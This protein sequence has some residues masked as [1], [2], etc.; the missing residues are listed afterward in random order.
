MREIKFRAWNS[1]MNKFTDPYLTSIDGL[2]NADIGG[3]ELNFLVIEMFTGLL[4]KDGKEIY[5][6]DI[7]RVYHDEI[8]TP[9][10]KDFVGAVKYY[11]CAFYVDDNTQGF[12]L[13]H[14]ITQWEVVG[15]IHQNPNLI[16]E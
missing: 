5:E 3:A 10:P 14:E 2:G 9:I 8:G 6:G 1:K 7:L 16:E 11:E 12:P 15:N 13:W 4:D